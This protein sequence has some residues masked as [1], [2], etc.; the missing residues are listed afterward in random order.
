MIHILI[1]KKYNQRTFDDKTRLMVHKMC[2]IQK[3]NCRIWKF[4][5]QHG[6][7]LFCP[8]YNKEVT[9][10]S[11][12][13]N[14]SNTADNFILPF[15]QLCHTKQGMFLQTPPMC[16]NAQLQVLRKQPLH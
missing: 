5:C 9:M 1:A 10:S 11:A 8:E 7:P 13:Y 2:K 14:I 4:C 12:I 16:S 15:Y 3:K 6:D